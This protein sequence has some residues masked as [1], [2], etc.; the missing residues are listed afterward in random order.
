MKYASCDTRSRH[1]WSSAN[2]H[3]QRRAG[4][5][6]RTAG[7]QVAIPQAEARPV[8]PVR[9]R[10][11]RFNQF[12]H[13]FKLDRDSSVQWSSVLCLIAEI[14]SHTASLCV[15]G[16]PNA[17]FASAPRQRFLLRDRAIV[18]GIRHIP[19]CNRAVF[20]TMSQRFG[21]ANVF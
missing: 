5:S 18:R 2:W 14:I 7:C 12:K 4:D 19:S 9:V 20:E 1:D 13:L 21:V 17:R 11:Y 15:S 10:S 8:N 6:R 3:Q 16:S